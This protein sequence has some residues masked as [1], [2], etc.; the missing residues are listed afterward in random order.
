MSVLRCYLVDDEELPLASL[1]RML[2]QIDRVEVIGSATDSAVAIPEIQRLH[3]DALFLDIHMPGID[4]FQLLSAL[5]PPPLVVFT[6]AYDHYAVRA[7]EVNS[8]DYLLKPV[9]SDRLR[10]AVSRLERR[11]ETR[12]PEAWPAARVLAAVRDAMKPQAWLRRVGTQSGENI[13]LL[14]LDQVTHFVSEDRYVYACTEGG[15]FLLTSSLSE[16]EPRLDPAQFVRIHR[17]AIVNLRFVGQVSR[18]FAG[19]VLIRLRNREKTELPVSRDRVRKL[20][21]ALGLQ[22]S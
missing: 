8:V 17:S 21:E 12:E 1:V 16:L 5:A 9:A 11:L 6:T 2:H 7:F 22:I 15:R 18:W 4:G 19:R 20:R 10:E 14:N 13:A 3:P